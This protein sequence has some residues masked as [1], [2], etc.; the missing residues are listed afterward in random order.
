MNIKG[1]IRDVTPGTYD[2]GMRIGKPLK[3]LLNAFY[4]VTRMWVC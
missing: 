1:S 3:F 4:I 2:H